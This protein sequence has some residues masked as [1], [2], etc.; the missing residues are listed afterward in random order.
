MSYT[1]EEKKRIRDAIIEILKV[2]PPLQNQDIRNELRKRG[3]EIR[4][5]SQIDRIL[6]VLRNEGL[7]KFSKQRWIS[8][9]VSKCDKCDGKGFV[10]HDN[11]PIAA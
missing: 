7:I 5:S 11:G 8:A 10:D 4:Y 6:Q 3:F 2:S 9:N 1:P